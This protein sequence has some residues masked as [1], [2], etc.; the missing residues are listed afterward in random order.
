MILH[1]LCTAN[2]VETIVNCCYATE[3]VLRLQAGSLY[4]HTAFLTL[5][6]EFTRLYLYDCPRHGATISIT[7]R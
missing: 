5:M 7:A 3:T 2:T 4:A 1:V 6:S